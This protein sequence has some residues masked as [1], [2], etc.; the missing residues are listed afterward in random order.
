MHL[1]GTYTF[2]TT[3]EK[4]WDLLNDPDVLARA[5]PGIKE[6]QLWGVDETNLIEYFTEM[7]QFVS[8]CHFRDCRHIYEPECA[9]Q[10]ALERG[11]FSRVRYEGYKRI[12]KQMVYKADV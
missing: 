4:L 1:E 7:T 6:L 8:G 9:V 11:A 5:T 12:M 2:N 3:Q 10:A